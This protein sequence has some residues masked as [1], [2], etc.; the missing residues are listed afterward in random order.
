M[1]GRP[2]RLVWVL[3]LTGVL[4]L[5][6]GRESSGGH[7]ADTKTDEG[8]IRNILLISVDTWRY[9]R[10]GLHGNLVKTPN[11]DRL[12]GEALHFRRAFSHNP[13]TLPA[14]VNILTGTTPLYHGIG[15]NSGFRLDERFMTMAEFF[16]GKGWN[17]GAF[18]G[19]FPLD[20]R[21]GLS[22]GFDRYDERFRTHSEHE[23]FFSERPANQVIDSFM[24]WNETLT[25][26]QGWFAFV[27]LFDPHQPYLPPKEFAE[28][29]PDD[30]Y[31]AEVA[32]TDRELGRLWAWL[33]SKGQYESTLI[34]LVGDHGEGL[35]EHGELTHA[36]FA[37]N[38]TIH[39][40]LFLRIPGVK[41]EV[42][43][44]NVSHVDIFP[45]L[46]E[47]LGMDAPV[48][49]QGRS[50]L[51]D[52]A[53]L[54]ER[55]IY[56]ESMTSYLNRGWAPLR[57]YIYKNVKYI[58]L[59]LQELYD[60]EN[61]PGEMN[62]LVKGLNW[63]SHRKNLEELIASMLGDMKSE[64]FEVMDPKVEKHLQSL[65]YLPGAQGEKK[66]VFLPKDDLKLLLSVQNKMLE[67]MA[68]EQSGKPDEAIEMFEQVVSEREDFVMV[69]S[70]LATTHKKLFEFD[71]AEQA[72]KRGI[73]ANPDNS[74]LLSKLGILLSEHGKPD[75][76]IEILNRAIAKES[77]NPENYNYLGVAHHRKGEF[78]QALEQ[79]AKGLELD[80][81][82]ALLYNNIGAAWLMKYQQS[83]RQD[84]LQKAF[85]GFNSALSID[86]GLH[87][88]LTG[89]GAAFGY[90]NQPERAMEDWHKAIN[91]KSDYPDPY[92]NL[93][94]M[95]TRMNRPAQALDIFLACRRN[96]QR[97]L[98]Q[99]ER[100]RL[101]RLISG[102]RR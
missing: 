60:L 34:V 98:K 59:P 73:N 66:T 99:G 32:F 57:G 41:A 5:S 77:F 96:C 45:T 12:A 43:D 40:P 53:P 58:D 18:I 49:L 29:Y 69:Y 83:K 81:N 6:C 47:A 90:D 62:N 94:I 102:L 44:Q 42:V 27:H 22:Q 36:Y 25:G 23:G 48:H 80:H 39:I 17:T 97:S 37:Y 88:A 76:A 33:K 63:K 91:A 52:R 75:E 70:L 50:L 13:C 93:G 87:S 79:F 68:M 65:G 92:F 100:A 14:H 19:A 38:S 10:V 11:I 3:I 31:S 74:Y 30:L 84:F 61:D 95:L 16:K 82:N 28:A 51:A 9:D 67:G 2:I 35:G 72:L 7:V 26:D 46:C 21:F 101:E 24:E 86:E 56:F 15:D 4:S 89:R 8:K 1:I 20:S 54:E 64:R 71:K 55:A 85:D 78:D